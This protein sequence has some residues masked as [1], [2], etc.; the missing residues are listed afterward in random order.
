M[1]RALGYVPGFSK[2]QGGVKARLDPVV[3]VGSWCLGI[4][5]F[6]DDAQLVPSSIQLSLE[7]CGCHN[8]PQ[9]SGSSG[10]GY[11]LSVISPTHHVPRLL[12]LLSGPVVL[13]FSASKG[14]GPQGTSCC[15]LL[16]SAVK[17]VSLVAHSGCTCFPEFE[18]FSWTWHMLYQPQDCWR[19]GMLLCS[20]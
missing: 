2:S 8:P 11:G 3:T 1:R 7:H 9:D 10:E 4:P 17:P 13:P 19:A 20:M 14:A 16:L 12:Y 5:S 18:V 15:L 6:S